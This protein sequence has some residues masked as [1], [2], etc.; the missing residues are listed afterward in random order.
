MAKYWG[1]RL[2]E[3]GRFV[4]PCYDG[5]FIAIGWLSEN[6]D[7][8]NSEKDPEKALESLKRRFRK[9][10]PNDSESSSAM[11][12][13][14]IFRFVREFK[15]DDIVLV[16]EPQ[17]RKIIIG[18]ITGLYQFVSNPTDGCDYSHRRK[19]E[20]LKTVSRD[21]FSQKLRNALVWLT[22]VSLEDHSLEIDELIQ[23]LKIEHPEIE[24]TGEGLY[25][26]VL[27]RL[28][29]MSPRDFE[30]FIAN[31]LGVI[32]FDSATP[33]NYV[34]DKGIDVIGSLNAGLTSVT[35]HVQVKKVSF[36]LGN[37][38]V[39]KIRGTLGPD[40][41]GAIVTTSRFTRQAEEES[42]RSSVKPITL[43]SG[44]NLVELILQH[45]DEINEE[46]QKLLNISKKEIP[47]KDK[48]IIKAR[49]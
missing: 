47:M 15:A 20:W 35:L 24:I 27:D 22:V 44:D 39:L 33:M 43:I 17:E 2:G 34:G 26:A 9:E 8:L 48:F 42:R 45:Y 23:G 40:E 30:K 38:E 31:L 7:W 18:K 36:A 6:L 46:Y 21:D 29:E 1:V 37:D 16:P 41:H 28:K 13:G 12:C 19:V 5:K 14:E 4:K 10:Y 49:A 11:K 32:G 25:E 3:G